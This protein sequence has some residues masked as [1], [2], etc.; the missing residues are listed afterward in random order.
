MEW[1]I[2]TPLKLTLDIGN[3]FLVFSV[4][5][6][7]LYS[8]QVQ[9][10]RTR[11]KK[12]KFVSEK[13]AGAM[14]AV[15]VLFAISIAIYSF[16]LLDLSIGS[17]NEFPLF[18]SGL[19]ALIIGY[20]TWSVGRNYLRKYHPFI[21]EKRLNDIRFGEMKSPFTGKPMKLLNENQ[22]DAHLT[23]EMIDEE[24]MLS[25]D[26]DVWLD[27]ANDYKVIERY[28]TRYHALVC[29]SCN[30]RTLKEHKEEIVR[31]PQAH[32]RGLLRKYYE[33]SHCGHIETKDVTLPSWEEEG[34]YK[35]IDKDVLEVEMS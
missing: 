19:V 27:E 28:D 11:S 18:V 8:V 25:V 10:I 7:L 4:F 14:M 20:M 22:E 17:L 12:Y 29:D 30:F 2:E 34:K 21:L 15:V 31:K 24:E 9:S 5:L 16:I 3:M 35:D 23:Q 6:Y 13:E 32:T 26:Y 33:C 1:F